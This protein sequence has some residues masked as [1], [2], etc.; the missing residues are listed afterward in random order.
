VDLSVD[1]EFLNTTEIEALIGARSPL[2]DIIGE[3]TDLCAV[4]QQ[5]AGAKGPYAALARIRYDAMTEGILLVIKPR[6]CFA[7]PPEILGYHRR[8]GKIFPQQ[9][10][11]D[12]FFDEEQWEAYRRFGEHVGDTLFGVSAARGKWAPSSMKGP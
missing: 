9:D 11:A 5:I 6:L 3:Y 7:E 2:M 1:I 4:P 10:T 8:S 12:Q